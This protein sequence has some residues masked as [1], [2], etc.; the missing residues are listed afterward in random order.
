L[1]IFFLLHGA[2]LSFLQA[3]KRFEEVCLFVNKK[4][5]IL[6]A[7]FTLYGKMDYFYSLI[8]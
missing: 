8:T 3:Y 1:S 4:L 5:A 6:S 7:F 2:D